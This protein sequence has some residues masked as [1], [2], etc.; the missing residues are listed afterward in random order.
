[1]K[2]RYTASADAIYIELSDALIVR[3]D[4]IEPGTLV[5]VDGSGQAVGIELLQPAR[6]WPLDEVVDQYQLSKEDSQILSN[7]W[8]ASD[9]T[10]RPFP[11]T[12]K[13]LVTQ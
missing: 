4:H 5:D 10:A 9:G 13:L 3:T 6:Q 8:G 12:D 7:W 11:I 1:M 2:I